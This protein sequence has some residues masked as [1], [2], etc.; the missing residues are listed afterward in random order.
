MTAP[1]FK[2]WFESRANPL[3]RASH[4]AQHFTQDALR[5]AF[6]AGEAHENEK[7]RVKREKVTDDFSF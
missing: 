1:S 5:A 3:S 7:W 6:E 4:L 2:E